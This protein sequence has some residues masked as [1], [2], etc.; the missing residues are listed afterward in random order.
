MWVAEAKDGTIMPIVAP[1]TD[2]DAVLRVVRGL[3]KKHQVQR[4]VF[5]TEAW[6]I[7][8]NKDRA[9]AG[10][11]FAKHR[12]LSEHPDRVEII[13]M[14]AEDRSRCVMGMMTILRPEHGKPKLM[15]LEMSPADHNEG[16]FTGLLSEA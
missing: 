2:K 12:S 13:M 10:M 11:E 14:T 3:F 16:R 6:T 4:Y 15:P 8:V 9:D 5:M 7:K 1:L